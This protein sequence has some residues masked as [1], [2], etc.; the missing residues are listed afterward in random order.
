MGRVEIDFTPEIVWQIHDNR[1]GSAPNYNP[2]ERLVTRRIDLL[3]RKKRRDKEKI[4]GMQ[5][6]VRL[7]PLAPSNVRRATKNIGDRVLFSMVMDPRTGSW[8][9]QK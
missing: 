2:L 8:F 1:F 9:D 3:M 5:Q 7:P 4:P 6:G